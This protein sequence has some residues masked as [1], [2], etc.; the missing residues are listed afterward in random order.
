MNV[1]I[2][3][4]L[5]GLLFVAGVAFSDERAQQPSRAPTS[6]FARSAEQWARQLEFE[7]DHLEED[8][9][10]E[11]GKYPQGLATQIDK[12]S[13][14]TAHF[15]QVLRRDAEPQHLLRDFE[16]MDVH[17]HQLVQMLEQSGDGW[18]R[19]QASRISYPDEQLHF[20]LRRNETDSPTANNE[21]IARLAHT[22]EREARS[23]QDLIERVT[24]RNDPMRDAARDFTD[25]VSHFHGVV[26]KGADFQHMLNDFSES[27]EH[28]RRMVDQINQSN[29]GLYLRR[30]AQN[31]NRVQTQIHQ[32]LTSAQPDHRN[33]VQPQQRQQ[34]QQPQ[35]P[36]QPQPPNSRPAIEFEIPGVGRFR[37]P[38]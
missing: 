31:V 16:E 15:R 21:I 37:I 14:A 1:S 25:A 24:L 23:L 33:A 18:L 12:A 9:F 27:D 7:L 17:I 22:L 34:R 35:Q 3:F 11:R 8:V 19:R 20:V 4:S 28:W 36:Q 6:S 38:R 2:P 26:E 10:Y 32:V 5:F 13:R 29:Y 30:N